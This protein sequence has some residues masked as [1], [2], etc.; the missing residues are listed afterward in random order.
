ME[1]CL[2]AKKLGRWSQRVTGC[3]ISWAERTTHPTSLPSSPPLVSTGGE[4]KV[5]EPGLEMLPGEPQAAEMGLPEKSK[6]NQSHREHGV[7]GGNWFG[8]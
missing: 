7:G 4:L 6:K 3:C 1:T 2:L 5:Q 8:G